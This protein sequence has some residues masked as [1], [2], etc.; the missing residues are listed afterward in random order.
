M[1]PGA[2]KPQASAPPAPST[3]PS[4]WPLLFAW[5][6]AV[7]FVVSLSYFVY[8]Y[9]FRFSRVVSG[10]SQFGPILVNTA[11]FT[12]FAAHHSV[13]ARAGAKAWLR[14]FLPPALER[15]VYTWIASLLFILVCWRWELVPGT[16]YRIAAPWSWIG[17]A[18][19]VSGVLLA[20][21]SSRAL[22]A[23]DLAGVRQIL[24][25]RDARAAPHVPLV[26]TGVYGFVRHPLYLGWALM[27]FGSPDMTATRLTFA[28]ISTLYLAV[29]IPWE[30]RGLVREFGAEYEAYRRTV[31][32]R[33]LPFV[34]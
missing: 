1:T 2:A 27:V 14:R 20:V 31:K 25:A 22:D 21:K 33:M 8:A 30:E 6:G 16:A 13:F 18:I 23:L 9:V 19:Q 11:L 32:W 12:V 4:A 7:V 28:V 5:G 24:T 34:Y 29:A 17:Y 3:P 26:T 15:S 10:E